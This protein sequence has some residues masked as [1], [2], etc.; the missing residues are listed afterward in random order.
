[1]IAVFS[2]DGRFL[3]QMD[4]PAVPRIGERVELDGLRLGGRRYLG[5]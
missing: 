1:M 2:G 3:A 4:L 5:T